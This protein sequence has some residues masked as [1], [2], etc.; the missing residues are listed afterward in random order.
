LTF[1][2]YR[3][4]AY[5]Y[6]LSYVSSLPSSSPEGQSA[7]ID[8]IA[9]ALRLPSLFDLDP[10]FKLDAVVSAKDHELFSLLQV[11]LNSGLPE[12]HSWLESHPTVLEKYGG[13][14]HYDRYHMF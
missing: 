6:T 2:S 7:A 14:V 8:A 4:T 10:L 9:L 1:D 5:Q 3:E 11:F 13:S 12:F